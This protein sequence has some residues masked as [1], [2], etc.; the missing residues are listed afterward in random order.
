VHVRDLHTGMRQERRQLLAIAATQLHD[1]PTRSDGAADGHRV[2]GQ[3]P[4]LG[5]GDAIPRQVAD[6]VEQRRAERVVEEA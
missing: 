4:T 1:A 6:R 5:G 2:P 3:Q